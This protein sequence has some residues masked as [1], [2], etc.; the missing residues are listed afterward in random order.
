MS[1]FGLSYLASD[2]GLISEMVGNQSKKTLYIELSVINNVFY[3][4]S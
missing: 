2:T 3:H 4:Y 1:T